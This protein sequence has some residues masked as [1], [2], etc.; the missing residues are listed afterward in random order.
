MFH[1]D[2]SSSSDS[3]EET[4]TQ[5][6]QINQYKS[7]RL[8]IEKS[9]RIATPPSNDPNRHVPHRSN[10]RRNIMNTEE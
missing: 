9:L 1:N 10:H 5:K 4:A 8:Q 7:R 6:F 3:D 2:F